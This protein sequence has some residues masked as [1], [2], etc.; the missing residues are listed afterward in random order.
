MKQKEID[1]ILDKRYK[2]IEK[3]ISIEQQFDDAVS[4]A[5]KSNYY[6]LTF[7]TDSLPENWIKFL[8][9]Y[10]IKINYSYWT[11]SIWKVLSFLRKEM[12]NTKSEIYCR[13]EFT[14]MPK[15]QLTVLYFGL[16]SFDDLLKRYKVLKKKEDRDALLDEMIN[17]TMDNK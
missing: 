3:K 6:K 4:F 10:G 15:Q 12:K 14:D 8:K 11:N 16:V 9:K 1:F 13:I 17:R 7:N 5:N 2:I